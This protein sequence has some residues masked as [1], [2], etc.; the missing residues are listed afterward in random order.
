MICVD[1][2]CANPT[3]LLGTTLVLSTSGS[4][5]PPPITADGSGNFSFLQCPSL[6]FCATMYNA[7]PRGVQVYQNVSYVVLVREKAYLLN[8]PFSRLCE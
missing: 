6:V 8:S 7:I 3:A 1:Q 5:F 2:T 4:Q